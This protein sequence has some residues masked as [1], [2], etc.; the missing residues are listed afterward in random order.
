MPIVVASVA[1][2]FVAIVSC[3]VIRQD[4]LVRIM[5]PYIKRNGKNTVVFGFILSKCDICILFWNIMLPTIFITTAIFASNFIESTYGKYNPYNDGFDCFYLTERFGTKVSPSTMNVA[6]NV[7]CF[8]WKINFGEALGQATGALAFVWLVVA[9]ETWIILNLGHKVKMC[10]MKTENKNG[11]C[12]ICYGCCQMTV[13]T[14]VNSAVYFAPRIIAVFVRYPW[15]QYFAMPQN[16]LIIFIVLSSIIL[17]CIPIKKEQQSLEDCC[18]KAME[19]RQKEQEEFLKN[20]KKKKGK[21]AIESRDQQSQML[22]IKLLKEMA[23][24]ECK[25]VLVSNSKIN[26]KEVMTIALEAFD[27]ITQG[28]N[29]ANITIEVD[30]RRPHTASS[31]AVAVKETSFGQW[32]KPPIAQTIALPVGQAYIGLEP[33]NLEIHGHSTRININ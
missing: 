26:E 33:I 25:K 12:S 5:F 32:R 21:S 16:F 31:T 4:K 13:I 17:F 22:Q 9:I 14:I 11:K 20:A 23:E 1:T 24:L 28:N 27:S 19:K 8:K 15:I 29:E 10:L 2:L 3:C 18:I 7:I 6:D 30:E